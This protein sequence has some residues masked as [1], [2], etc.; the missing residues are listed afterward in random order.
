MAPAVLAAVQAVRTLRSSYG[1]TTR[2]KPR[3]H[4]LPRDAAAARPF[5]GSG[6]AGA[7]Y[8]AAL[9]PSEGCDVEAPLDNSSSLPPAPAG[10]GV[11]VVSESLA[12]AVQ[13]AGVLDPKKE[14]LKLSAKRDD[15]M[16]RGAALRKKRGAAT[17]SEKTPAD[18]QASDAEKLSSA[19]AELRLVEEHIA[20]ME[21]LSL[22]SPPS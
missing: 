4:V 18:V 11:A 21:K 19:E 6:G 2:A 7:G 17:Y 3:L 16:S 13:L 22:S 8:L 5:G 14:L 1:L 12:V 10:C 9:A 20:E 15:A